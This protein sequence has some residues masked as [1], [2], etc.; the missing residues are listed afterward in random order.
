ML[1]LY[2][3]RS[4][5]AWMDTGLLITHISWLTTIEQVITIVKHEMAVD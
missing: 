2:I 5:V 3:K 4:P 1:K